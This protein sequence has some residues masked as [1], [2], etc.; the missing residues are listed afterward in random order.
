MY[1][2]DR[3]REKSVAWGRTT[4]IKLMNVEYYSL[5]FC[6]FWNTSVVTKSALRLLC[7]HEPDRHPSPC[8]GSS[9]L[10][11]EVIPTYRKCM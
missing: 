8:K 3:F 5:V 7:C 10:S 6:T 2:K 9:F 4:K 1:R 11:I